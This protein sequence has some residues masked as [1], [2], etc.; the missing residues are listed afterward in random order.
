MKKEF[1][2]KPWGY[3]EILETNPKYTVKRL[4]MKKGCQCSF[5]YHEK[6][7]ETIL[8]L[9]GNLTILIEGKE[10]V[11]KPGENV[12]IHPFDKHRMTAK[13]NDCLYLECSTSEL[14][15]V[16]RIKDDYDRK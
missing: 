9:S 3:E 16:I 1:I 14:N 5:Q 15:D 2:E 11:L 7:Q 12:T 6:K 4:F 10:G 8:S 13:D